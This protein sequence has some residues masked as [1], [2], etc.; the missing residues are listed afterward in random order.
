MSCTAEAKREDVDDKGLSPVGQEEHEDQHQG[1]EDQDAA[2]GRDH[3]QDDDE[4][5]EARRQRSARD[6]GEPT[7][8]EREEH[9]LTHIPFRPWCEACIRGK[10]KRKPSLRIAGAY[11]LSHSCRVR[12]DYAYLTEDV[13]VSAGDHG[14]EESSKAESTMTMLVVQESQYRSVWSYAVESKGTADDWVPIQ[15]MEDLETIGVKNEKIVL[16]SDQET[17]IVDL[18][19]EIARLRESD[20]GTSIEHSA[21]GESDSNASVERAI[22]DVEGQIRTLKAGLEAKIAQKIRLANPIV[23]WM[24]RHAAALITRCR[25]RPS[26]RTSLEMIKG[27]RTNAP[28]AEFGE[29]ILFKIPKTKLNPGKFDDQW[30]SGT[31]L[32]FDMRSM[33][34]LV[35]TTVGVFKCTDFKRKSLQERSTLR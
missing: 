15:I 3:A 22:Q 33:E 14:E 10:G 13:E 31:Y 19:K 2:E 11:S 34:T 8:E 5:E 21:V 16:K 25:I 20:F 7:R 9:D 29:H 28:I 6:P 30:S 27:R 18:V 35:G 26:G 1:S 4:E 32:G 23:P 17:A 12:M 24:I